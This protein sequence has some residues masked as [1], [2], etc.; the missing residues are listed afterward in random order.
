MFLY[1]LFGFLAA[2][3]AVCALWVLFGVFF[4]GKT[5]C[6]ASVVCP[7]GK[8]IAVIRRYCYLRE[9]GLACGELTV[10]DS[11]LNRKQQQYI[12][13]RYP[14]ITFSTRQAWLAAQGKE[15]ASFAGTGNFAGNHRCGGISEL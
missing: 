13:T 3:G 10:L 14:Y 11:K 7:A 9:M 4:R 8:E 2:F 5:Q 6:A 15:G 1:V 12:Q